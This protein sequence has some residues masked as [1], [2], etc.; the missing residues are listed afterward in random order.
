MIQLK[1]T[2]AHYSLVTASNGTDT[3]IYWKL[4]QTT[5]ELIGVVANNVIT[6]FTT[7]FVFI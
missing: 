1:G 7:G 3:E 5:P 6:D 4:G 2:S